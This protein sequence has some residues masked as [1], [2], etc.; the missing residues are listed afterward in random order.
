M[1]LLAASYYFYACWRPEYLILIVASTL[2]DYWAGISMGRTKN[3]IRRRKYLLFSLVCNLG[4]LFTFKYFNFINESLR[5]AMDTLGFSYRVPSLNVLLP[6]GISFYTFQTLSYSIDVYRGEKTPE[7]H[8]GIFALYVSFFPQLVAGPIERSDRLLPQFYRK[9]EIDWERIKSGM[10]LMLWGFFKKL[11][12][13]DRVAIYI[14]QIYADPASY[15][16]LG[17]LLALY[18]FM[19][20]IYC[21]FSGYSDIAIGAARLMGYR[22]SRNFHRPTSA[23]SIRDMWQR[24]HISMTSWI[25]DYIYVPIAR[26]KSGRWHKRWSLFAAFLIIGLWH[27]AN[28]TYILF[29]ALHGFF[30]IFSDMTRRFRN[31]IAG[32]IFPHNKY[33]KRIH[34]IWK[35][36]FTFNLIMLSLAFFRAR[37]ISDAVIVLSNIFR[38]GGA[39]ITS[40]MFSRYELAIALASIWF[41][42]GIQWLN[43]KDSVYPVLSRQ[44]VWLRWGVCYSLVFGI[45]MFGQLGAKPF[46]Y[47]GF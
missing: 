35:V 9:K 12:I 26:G 25:M 16:G 45:L 44:P 7:R 43:S 18:L 27:G 29:G 17:V 4:I 31:R 42:E 38:R 8:P 46:I 36:I 3:K 30:I 5:S 15:R 20:Q 32:Y 11:V 22:L 6:V 24:W 1:L 34:K 21:D 37:S 19:Y 33:T 41:L 47:F 13:A 39:P 40:T 10:M 2:V 23:N 28:W 14:D